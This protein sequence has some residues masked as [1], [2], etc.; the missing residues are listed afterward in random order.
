MYLLEE[1]VVLDALLEVLDDLII[2]YSS[3]LVAI[4]KESICVVPKGLL[5]SHGD[6][7]EMMSPPRPAA[8]SMEVRGERSR[9]SSPEVDTSHGEVVQP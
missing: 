2:F 7:T 9:Q 8:R 4:L 6:L 5:R 1:F 3:Q